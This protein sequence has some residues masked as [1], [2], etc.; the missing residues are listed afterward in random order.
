MVGC[1]FLLE[2]VDGE[3]KWPPLNSVRSEGA[4]SSLQRCSLVDVVEID[5]ERR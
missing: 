1:G 2:E 4:L 3:D 5:K